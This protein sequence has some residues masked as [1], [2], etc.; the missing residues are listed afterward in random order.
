ML[1]ARRVRFVPD[2]VARVPLP[3]PLVAL[4]P[5]RRLPGGGSL[6]TGGGAAEVLGLCKVVLVLAAAGEERGQ[7]GRSAAGKGNWLLELCFEVQ[8]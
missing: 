2:A 3:D 5:W 1:H 8:E 4:R 6:G 7:E